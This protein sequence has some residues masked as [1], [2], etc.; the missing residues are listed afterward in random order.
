VAVRTRVEEELRAEE[1][2]PASQS[3]ASLF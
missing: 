3:E 2:E 1:G